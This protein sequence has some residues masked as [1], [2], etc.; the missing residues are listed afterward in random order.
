MYKN[1][2]SYLQKWFGAKPVLLSVLPPPVLRS[3]RQVT[4]YYGATRRLLVD[5]TNLD[6]RPRS[7]SDHGAIDQ[8]C[9]ILLTHPGHEETLAA[10]NGAVTTGRNRP[11]QRP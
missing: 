1:P 5:G 7:Y 8:S 9:G 10:V 3:T 11:H 6:T 2:I 4:N